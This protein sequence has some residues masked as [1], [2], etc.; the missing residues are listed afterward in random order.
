MSKYSEKNAR[1]KALKEHL[2]P[3]VWREWRDFCRGKRPMMVDGKP[4]WAK[5]GAFTGVLPI[6]LPE[7]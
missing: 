1:R 5:N 7:K 6:T 2:E 4:I 3:K